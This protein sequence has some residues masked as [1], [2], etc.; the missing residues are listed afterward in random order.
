MES[1][2]QLNAIVDTAWRFSIALPIRESGRTIVATP[3][4]VHIW[5]NI[6]KPMYRALSISA[7]TAIVRKLYN[8]EL[9]NQCC[10]AKLT[11]L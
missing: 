8:Y 3:A 10:D 5:N 4:W 6:G 1:F 9:C 11:Q 2:E 7:T